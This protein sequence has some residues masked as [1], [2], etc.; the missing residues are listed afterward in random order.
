MYTIRLDLTGLDC[1]RKEFFDAMREENI[2]CQVHYIPTY[3]FSNYRKMGYQRGICPA[4]EEV[5]SSIMSI[6]LF[7]KMTDEDQNYVIDT[8]KRLI[9]RYKR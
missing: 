6:P 9:E 5:Y 2:Y 3:Y 8:V 4:A 7:P 1:T